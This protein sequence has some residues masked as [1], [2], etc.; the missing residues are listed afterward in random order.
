MVFE[1]R[2]EHAS[3]WAAIESIAAK[4]GCAD[5]TLRG[6]VRQHERDSGQHEAGRPRST[7]VKVRR[8]R[9]LGGSKH[10]GEEQPSF[11]VGPA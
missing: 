5:E 11:A 8:V 2:G 3:Q 1:H 10:L 4:I 9:P 7:P 6:W